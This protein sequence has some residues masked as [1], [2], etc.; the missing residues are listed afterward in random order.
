MQIT[1][2]REELKSKCLELIDQ[3]E[4]EGLSVVVTR[5]GSPFVMLIPIPAEAEPL[6]NLQAAPTVA[7]D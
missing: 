7:T 6:H 2:S 3:I 4:A 5:D 1:I